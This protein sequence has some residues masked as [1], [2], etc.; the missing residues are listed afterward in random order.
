M[1]YACFVL[2]SL[3]YYCLESSLVFISLSYLYVQRRRSEHVCL[4]T[5]CPPT[6]TR[7]LARTQD[8]KT[9]KST[10]QRASPHVF[11]LSSRVKKGLQMLH[12]PPPPSIEENEERGLPSFFF[13]R[14]W[15]CCL[16]KEESAGK[17][18]GG[19]PSGS[20]APPPHCLCV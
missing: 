2:A 19:L 13:H 20:S 6:H 3:R 12:K 10:S 15:G 9:R 8:G 16:K 14:S 7:P 4:W 1:L 18:N 17:G 5:P 11:I